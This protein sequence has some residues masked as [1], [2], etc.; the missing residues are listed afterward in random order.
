VAMDNARLYMTTRMRADELKILLRERE[1]AQSRLLH[2]E[3]MSALGRLVASIAH[4]INNPL[5]SVQGCLTLAEEEL[6]SI[7]DALQQTCGECEGMSVVQEREAGL[8][9]YL[10]IVESEI[11]RIAEIVR[12]M[13]DF[14]RPARDEMQPT[15]LHV[16][17]ESVL[18]LV[19]KQLQYSHVTV[20]RK[21]AS[22]LPDVYVNPDHLRQVFLNLVLNAIDAMP[23]GGTLCI[24]TGLGLENSSQSS[25]VVRAAGGINDQAGEPDGEQKRSTVRIEFRDSGEGISPE[26]QAR[27][28]EPFFT[29]KQ[30]GSGLG[31]SI[32]YGIIK[33]HNG[34]L[35]VTSQKGKGTTF[36]ILLPV[37]QM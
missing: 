36:T 26:V 1:Q 2:S 11:E 35:E 17:L 21:W 16:V 18:A 28:F 4:E 32:S 6:D 27:V 31:L 3:K 15:D 33:S 10:E 34:Q 9:R 22:S 25:R 29:T 7:P 12:R 30:T 24:R 20:E 14:Y 23:S 8:R 37:E 19:G 13:R 5:Q